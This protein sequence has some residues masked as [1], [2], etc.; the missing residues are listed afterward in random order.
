MPYISPIY[1]DTTRKDDSSREFN[2]QCCADEESKGHIAII[3]RSKRNLVKFYVGRDVSIDD[4][5]TSFHHDIIEL[6]KSRLQICSLTYNI[7]HKQY[8]DANELSEYGSAFET[9]F[10]SAQV[11]IVIHVL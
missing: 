2:L 1:T 5:L 8:Q 6:D 11:E 3:I 9:L 10:G 4:I 7:E